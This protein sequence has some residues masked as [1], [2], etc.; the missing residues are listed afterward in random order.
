MPFYD[1]D[2]RR[3]GGFRVLRSIDRRNDPCACP[4]CGETAA[5]VVASAPALSLVPATVRLAN[6]TNE[7]SRDRP[8]TSGE[9][10][11]RARHGRGCGCCSAMSASRDATRRYP[12]GAKAGGAKGFPA[13]RPWMISH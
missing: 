1:F 6:D 2:C 7:R 4:G 12:G 9:W 5:R 3:C 13:R 8:M 10:M 11:S